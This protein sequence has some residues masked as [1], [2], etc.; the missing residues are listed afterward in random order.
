MKLLII[1]SAT[2]AAFN[3]LFFYSI[4]GKYFSS[5]GFRMDLFLVAILCCLNY[6][7]IELKEHN[8]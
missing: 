3:I 5:S 1:I 7:L 4:T 8:K 6:I 2:F